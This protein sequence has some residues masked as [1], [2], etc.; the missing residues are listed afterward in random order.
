M[1]VVF[2]NRGP[3]LE[4]NRHVLRIPPYM[5]RGRVSITINV[6]KGAVITY[7]IGSNESKSNTTC[8]TEIWFRII[9][10][11]CGEDRSC[12]VYARYGKVKRAVCHKFVGCACGFCK[13]KKYRT[14]S[15]HMIVWMGT[16]SKRLSLGENCVC[17]ERED[18]G[19]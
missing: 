10:H 2:V 12:G 5:T 17:R 8:T 16:S 14:H 6:F 4:G 13:K 18:F 15:Q 9:G 3:S 19:L 11:P 7:A 1:I